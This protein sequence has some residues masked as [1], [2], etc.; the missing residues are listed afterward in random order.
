MWTL[1]GNEASPDTVHCLPCGIDL[2]VSRREGHIILTGDSSISRRHASLILTHSA[3]NLKNP[4]SD[5]VIKLTDL[6]AKYGT[7]VNDGIESDQKMAEQSV[8]E[9]NAGDRIRFGMLTNTWRLVHHDL[10]VT[11]S[12]VRPESKA[13][14]T[15]ALLTLGG[16]LVSEWGLSCSYLIMNSITLTVKVVCAL[17]SGHYIV[18]PEFLTNLANAVVKRT[19]HPKPAEYQ[20]P[21]QEVSISGTQAS[22]TPDERR[23]KLLTSL[24]FLFST[25]KQFKR[26]GLA[27][28]LA[29]GK[30]EELSDANYHHLASSPPTHILVQPIPDNAT[31][32]PLY[33]AA[34]NILKDQKLAPIPESDIGL[35]ILFISTQRHCNPAFRMASILKRSASATSQPTQNLKIYATETQD[36][37][38]NSMSLT[39]TRVVAETAQST[40]TSRPTQPTP[41]PMATLT[42]TNKISSKTGCEAGKENDV[43][44]VKKRPHTS[45]GES[46][47]PAV[48]RSNRTFHPQKALE[49]TQ[50]LQD[51]DNVP[52]LQLPN[53]NFEPS[54]SSTQKKAVLHSRQAS[55]NS[56]QDMTN[57]TEAVISRSVTMVPFTLPS[58]KTETL[59]HDDEV[60]TQSVTTIKEEV[61]TLEAIEEDILEEADN[62]PGKRRR[63][64]KTTNDLVLE[65]IGWMSSAIKTRRTED[66]N[67]KVTD[68]K[69]NTD[70]SSRMPDGRSLKKERLSSDGSSHVSRGGGVTGSVKQEAGALFV[71]PALSGRRNRG[72]GQTTNKE[73]ANLF[74]LPQ[75][76]RAAQRRKLAHSNVPDA[77]NH[78]L[79]ETATVPDA[80]LPTQTHTAAVP[81]DR[82]ICPT[83]SVSNS[84]PQQI[85]QKTSDSNDQGFISKKSSSP[86]KRSPSEQERG[87]G[88]VPGQE[89]RTIPGD[90]V[91]ELS[92]TLERS[93]VVVEVASL[94]RQ[95]QQ[96]S[97]PSR[98]NTSVTRNGLVNFKRFRKSF[99]DVTQL[100]RILGGVDLVP[101]DS[102]Q[103]PQR[104]AWLRDNPDLTRELEGDDGPVMDNPNTTTAPTADLD[105]FPLAAKPRKRSGSYRTTTLKLWIILLSTT[106]NTTL[107]DTRA[108]GPTH[109]PSWPTR[110]LTAGIQ[111]RGR[112]V[113]YPVTADTVAVERVTVDYEYAIWRAIPKVFPTVTIHGCGFH[114]AQWREVEVR[115]R[116]DR[117]TNNRDGG[118]E[119][120]Q[121]RNPFYTPLPLKSP[122]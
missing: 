103:N 71:L 68:A 48:K 98:A 77:T 53:G 112:K 23:Q 78:P 64:E 7:F 34:S 55:E 67:K 46:D 18:T 73:D 86:V 20:P 3:A 39:G 120:S 24:T 116:E 21:L 94:V 65:E 27:V 85:R 61:G 74:A 106:Q 8:L 70:N 35:A 13:A 75:S 121:M 118:S 63:E 108:V 83:V 2:L 52:D 10:V 31:S 16:H 60:P 32:N 72:V 105:L 115:V 36:M 113:P 102:V 28:T 17:A 66:V 96:P 5:T 45:S 54:H 30:V 99:G 90:M 44:N 12:A 4:R 114:W 37:E 26:M 69:R 89:D 11:T 100:P 107:A 97:Q 62:R 88:G 40:T 47:S 59:S 41:S 80:D 76:S 79:S 43:E 1:E 56:Q 91:G 122:R 81:S 38:S 19:R 117:Q 50:P 6:G 14:V 92:T 9:L 101:H 29:G 95:P 58:L 22:F 49:S 25:A 111:L 33:I 93:M 84:T 110:E 51:Q 15:Q 82:A 57:I 109:T 104:D 119:S 87:R 42:T